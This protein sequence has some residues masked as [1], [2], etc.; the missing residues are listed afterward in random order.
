MHRLS[1]SSQASMEL[2]A[3]VTANS[4]LVLGDVQCIDT[5]ISPRPGSDQVTVSHWSVNVR[6][7]HMALRKSTP[8]ML[9]I[10]SLS[11]IS[12]VCV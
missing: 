2:T 7:V 1:D 11:M 10:P 9:G 5:A 12:T 6:V 4:P 8:K 3:A